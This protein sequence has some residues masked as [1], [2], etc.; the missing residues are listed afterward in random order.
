MEVLVTQ[1]GEIMIINNNGPTGIQAGTLRLENSNEGIDKTLFKKLSASN[2]IDEINISEESQK[3][4]DMALN[5]DMLNPENIKTHEND[6]SL[7]FG[8]LFLDKMIDDLFFDSAF[9]YKDQLKKLQAREDT[10][11]QIS[12]LEK[13]YIRDLEKSINRVAGAL[14]SYFDK[15]RYMNEMF[16]EEP[17]EDLFDE[18]LFKENLKTSVLEIKD[19]IMNTEKPQRNEV[20]ES[21]TAGQ[22]TNT[23]ESMSY[24]DIKVLYKFSKKPPK[25]GDSIDNYDVQALDKIISKEKDSNKEIM[26]LPLSEIV[27]RSMVK[28]NN[29]VSEGLIK[30]VAYKEEQKNA[31]NEMQEYSRMIQHL[32]K[33]LKMIGLAIDKIEENGELSP[34][35]K[36]LMRYLERKE[37]LTEEYNGLKAE[38][39][40]RETT[41]NNLEDNKH[42]IVETETYKIVKAQYDE[43][44]FKKDK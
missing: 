39:D 7:I 17:I 42:V 32:L 33:R 22:R 14:N 23:L 15:G 40:R 35:N 3:L 31:I 27:K 43:K 30:Y 1:G 18:D 24:H 38:K 34:S 4:L 41:F 5:N 11:V 21:I 16:S 6:T 26:G 44:M 28:V 12:K 8:D 13:T 25:F 29:R 19:H 2:I 10:S 37:G 20:I 36:R 9:E